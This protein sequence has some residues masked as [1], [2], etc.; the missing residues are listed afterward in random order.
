M[1]ISSDFWLR[2]NLQT[3]YIFMNTWH[4]IWFVCKYSLF[5]IFFFVWGLCCQC[6]GDPVL[7]GFPWWVGSEVGLSFVF[8]IFSWSS[9][10]FCSLSAP[11][12]G[13]VSSDI[14]YLALVLRVLVV[15]WAGC[16]ACLQ[17]LLRVWFFI[18]ASLGL[19]PCATRQVYRPWFMSSRSSHCWH[20]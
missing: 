14:R 19:L 2:M 11:L 3:L 1:L 15:D 9:V 5:Q 12:T 17:S 10:V 13:A 4:V 6:Q 8:S 18:C 20:T 16:L 7:R